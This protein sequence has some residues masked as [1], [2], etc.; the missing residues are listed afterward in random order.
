MNPDGSPLVVNG[1]TQQKFS[2][3]GTHPNGYN[4]WYEI[5][6]QDVGAYAGFRGSLDNGLDWDIS[7]SVGTSRVDNTISDT[8]N[9]LLGGSQLA[10][11]AID[12]ANVQTAFYIGSQ[13]NTERTVRA[14]FSYDVETDAVENMK[15]AFGAQFRSEQNKNVVG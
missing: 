13:V 8:H 7:G 11:G 6:A 9:P 12:Y 2:G 10:S 15:V 14:D 4:P 1:V 3:L 5:D